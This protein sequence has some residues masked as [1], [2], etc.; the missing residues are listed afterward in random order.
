MSITNS[1][2][3]GISGLQAH[4]DAISVVG[5]NIANTSTIGFKRA[6]AS[7]NDMLGGELNGQRLGGGV[8]VSGTQTMWDQGSIQNTGNPLDLAI[9]GGL[10]ATAFSPP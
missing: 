8:R 10:V 2:Y 6:R 9:R 3:I 5:D 1:L 7:F 4:G